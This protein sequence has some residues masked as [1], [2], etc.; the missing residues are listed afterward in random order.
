[1][2]QLGARLRA[3]TRPGGRRRGAAR[4]PPPPRVAVEQPIERDLALAEQPLAPDGDDDDEDDGEDDL[5]QPVEER[6]VLDPPQRLAEPDDT[7]APRIEPLTEPIPPMTSIV[8]TR[9][10]RSK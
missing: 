2:A 6:R 5:A 7:I 1:M 4:G 9:N 3:L 10:V 8:M